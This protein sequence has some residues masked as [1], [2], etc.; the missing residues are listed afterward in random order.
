MQINPK[1]KVIILNGAGAAIPWGAPSTNQITNKI[2]QDN[3]FKSRTGQPLGDWIYQKLKQFYH[4]DPESVNFETILNAVD[5]LCSYYSAELRQGHSKFKTQ[6]PA[7]FSGREELNEIIDYNRIYPFDKNR[8]KCENPRLK[9]YA[10]WDDHDY[11]FEAVYRYFIN[12]IIEEVAGYD[13]NCLDIKYETLN[14]SF[15][16]FLSSCSDKSVIRAYTLNY[17]RIINKLSDVTFFEGFELNNENE[18]KFNREKVLTDFQTNSI[19][20]LHGNIYYNQDW[21]RNVKIADN[22]I[23]NYGDNSSDDNDQES[24]KL[25]NSNI[26]TGLNK[27]SRILQNPYSQFYYTFYND[28]MKAEIIFIV[29]YSFTDIHINKAIIEGSIINKNQKIIV[30]GYDP[31]NEEDINTYN[32]TSDYIQLSNRKAEMFLDPNHGIYNINEVE[33]SDRIFYFRKGFENFLNW[34]VWKTI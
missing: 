16:N 25:I 7:F 23:Y 15:N 32:P 29:G 14:K 28:C 21:P 11:F 27:S 20:S 5:W 17:D 26:I 3:L 31:I 22:P 12:L 30:V 4:F 2:C 10:F 18:L 8:W 6:I 19:Y 33:N 34:N 24:R 13:K 9:F 1:S